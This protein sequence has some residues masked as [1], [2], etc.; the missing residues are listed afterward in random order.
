MFLIAAQDLTALRDTTSEPVEDVEV[1]CTP[2]AAQRLLPAPPQGLT[3][4]PQS[5]V[6]FGLFVLLDDPLRS[7]LANS[8]PGCQRLKRR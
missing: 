8:L 3:R 1:S 5:T 6:L 4:S 2:H 7:Y